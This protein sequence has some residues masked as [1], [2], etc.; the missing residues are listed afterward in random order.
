MIIIIIII[1]LMSILIFLYL[2]SINGLISS[3]NGLKIGKASGPDGIY[4]K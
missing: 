3:V 2:F 1:M 4:L